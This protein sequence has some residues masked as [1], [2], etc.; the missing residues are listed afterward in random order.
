MTHS[1]LARP[2]LEKRLRS[3]LYFRDIVMSRDR[4]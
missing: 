2:T 3:D 4:L 1:S